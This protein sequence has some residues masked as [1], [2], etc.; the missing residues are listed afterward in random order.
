M[1]GVV[2]WSNH[3]FSDCSLL[4]SHLRIQ[5]THAHLSACIRQVTVMIPSYEAGLGIR[6]AVEAA[7]VSAHPIAARNKVITVHVVVKVVFATLSKDSG[8]L[9]VCCVLPVMRLPRFGRPQ[10]VKTSLKAHRVGGEASLTSSWWC[11][12]SHRGVDQVVSWVPRPC[13]V[14]LNIGSSRA[15]SIGNTGICWCGWNSVGGGGILIRS[16][17]IGVL[18][19]TVIPLTD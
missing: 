13:L 11:P 9:R 6:G 17:T 15:T 8:F 4:E 5:F 10:V 7:S 1:Y 14:H 12:S 16:V 19:R 3:G 18:I 2:N